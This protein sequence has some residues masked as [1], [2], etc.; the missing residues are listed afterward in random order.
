MNELAQYN[1]LLA[2]F[3]NPLIRNKSEILSE[4]LPLFKQ[5]LNHSKIPYYCSECQENHFSGEIYQN[6]NQNLDISPIFPKIPTSADDA[7]GR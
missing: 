5:L 3:V 7:Q 6:H 1:I 4:I 2:N